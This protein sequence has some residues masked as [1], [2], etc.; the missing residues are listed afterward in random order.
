DIA[1]Y[2]AEIYRLQCLIT[3]MQ[4]KRDRLVVHLRDYSAL[5]SPIR[6]VPNE[7]LCVI[8]GHYCR[9]YKTARAPVKLV[10]ICS[11]WR[12]VVTSTPSLW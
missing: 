3:L 12:S 9:S 8:F 10:S 7:V 11:H 1:D 5:V 4:H 2:T 6:R